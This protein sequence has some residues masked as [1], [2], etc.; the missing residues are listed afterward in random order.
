MELHGL[1]IKGVGGAYTVQTDDGAFT[2]TAR[3]VFRNRATTPLVGDRVII[4]VTDVSKKIATLHTIKPRENELRRPPAA[5]IGQ[6]IITVATAQPAFHAGLL[7]RF[8]LLV[9]NENIPIVICANKLDLAQGTGSEKP[10]V[11][12]AASNIFAPYEQAGYP[13]IYTCALTGHGLETLRAKMAGKLNLFAGPSGVGKSS[14]INSLSPG[15][16][17]ET[18]ELSAKLDRGKHTTRHTEIFPLGETAEAG[19]CF[20]T[21]G[22]T[23]LDINHIQ[24]NELAP[25]FREFRPFISE[26]R[27]KNCLHHHESDCAVKEQIG[28]AIHP[29]RYDGYMKLLHNITPRPSSR[30]F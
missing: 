14:L 8:L 1:I 20:D 4:T 11:R 18:G 5:N 16:N 9:E 10:H 2:C 7:D 28:H 30:N 22:F 6:V 15:L 12:H 3:G 24:K 23:S 17:L 19:F 26:C 21:S 27:F 29:A 13:V 25:L